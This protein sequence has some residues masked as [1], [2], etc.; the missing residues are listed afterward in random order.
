[1]VSRYFATK[2]G[3]ASN[4]EHNFG[5]GHVGCL[6]RGIP[7]PNINGDGQQK[8]NKRGLKVLFLC[9]SCPTNA[10]RLVKPQGSYPHSRMSTAQDKWSI[11]PVDIFCPEPNLPGTELNIAIKTMQFHLQAWM[12]QCCLDSGFLPKKLIL[13]L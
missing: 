13:F 3:Q 9:S 11:N 7:C 5:A 10:Q 1:M 4:K 12:D 8:W 2:V 6:G